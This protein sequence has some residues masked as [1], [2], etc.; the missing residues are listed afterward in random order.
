MDDGAVG[1]AWLWALP[2]NGVLGVG[3]YWAARHGFRQPAGLTR[4][5]A[6]A[7]L[8]WT[9]ATLGMEA[10]GTLGLVAPLPLLIWSTAGLAIG[11]LLRAIDR[12]EVP[13]GPS[14]PSGVGWDG[15]ATLAVGL[16]VWGATLLGVQS[17]LFPVK[18]V[19]DGPI[20]HL[21]FAA[22]WW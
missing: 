21:Y 1:L 2:L 19:S 13:D 20:Y 9:W 4:G 14:G 8:A 5:L 16:V 17:L 10:L 12:R 15:R 3:A 7:I 11:G 22:R 18:V 6:A